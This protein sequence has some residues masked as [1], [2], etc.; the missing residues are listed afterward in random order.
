MY[1]TILPTRRVL[2]GSSQMNILQNVILWSVLSITKEFLAWCW[3]SV[4]FALLWGQN[5][6]HENL[7]KCFTCHFRNVFHCVFNTPTESRII[8]FNH[9]HGLTNKK[10]C[11]N[12]LPLLSW[13]NLNS[14]ALCGPLW[15]SVALCGPLWP[16]VTAFPVVE[17]SR[18]KIKVFG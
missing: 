4:F 13:I 7:V 8:I 5:I 17:F 11:V 16:S 9:N 6:S 18:L 15:P 2:L 3:I 12:Q 1:W 14:V 10:S